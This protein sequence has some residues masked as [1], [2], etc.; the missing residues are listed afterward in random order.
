[1]WFLTTAPFLCEMDIAMR[2]TAVPPDFAALHSQK[3][4]HGLVF[5]LPSFAIG[6]IARTASHCAHVS[7]LPAWRAGWPTTKRSH[8]KRD[9]RTFAT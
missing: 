5:A 1:M 8:D 2:I 7:L 4:E 9:I 3:H 6:R